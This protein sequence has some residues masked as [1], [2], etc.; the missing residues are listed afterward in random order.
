[1]QL[2]STEKIDVLNIGLMLF[3]CVI[4]ILLPF[5]LFLIVYAILGPLHYLTE[6]SWLHDRNYFSKGKYDAVIL[7]VIGLLLTAFQFKNKFENFIDITFPEYFNAEL[8]Y[9]AFLG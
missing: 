5:E 7:V 4:A 2:T 8:A 1:M 3:S 9:V 6:I